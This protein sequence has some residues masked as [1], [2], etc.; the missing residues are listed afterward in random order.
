MADEN[1]QTLHQRSDQFYMLIGHCIAGRA[2]VDE[3]L[4]QIFAVCVRPYEQAA[5]VYYRTPG[6]DLRLKLV[7][8]LVRSVLPRRTRKSGGHDHPCVK[9]WVRTFGMI[10]P[11]FTTRRRIA[12]HRVEMK[13]IHN[14]LAMFI[15]PDLLG[16]D[17]FRISPSPH[18]R[19]RAREA[20]ATPL[21]LDDL[22]KHIMDINKAAEAVRGF[23]ETLIAHV[24]ESREQDSPQ[25]SS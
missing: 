21:M 13:Q 3:A 20:D 7:D 8:E 14:M 5:I 15:R 2:H 23:R 4:F 19:V 9:S 11:L 6:L 25:D 17:L 10:D 18:E 22:K 1:P 24:S 16:D 12:H